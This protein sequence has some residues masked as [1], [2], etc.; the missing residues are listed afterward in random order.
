[1]FISRGHSYHGYVLFKQKKEE[2]FK[3]RRKVQNSKM[4]DKPIRVSVLEGDFAVMSSVG[5]PLCLCPATSKLFE[6]E[7]SSMDS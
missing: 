1:M 6:T 3:V 7:R 2:E 5:L 4:A